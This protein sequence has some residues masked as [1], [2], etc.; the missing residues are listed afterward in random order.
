MI[1]NLFA[2]GIVVGRLYNAFFYQSKRI[3]D[4]EPTKQEFDEFLKFIENQKSVL[5][6]LW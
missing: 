3:L 1:Q 4:R 5:E 6:H 2:L